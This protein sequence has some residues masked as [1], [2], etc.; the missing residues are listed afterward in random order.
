MTSPLG[1]YARWYFEID[2]SISSNTNIIYH[3]KKILGDKIV[4][5]LFRS[6]FIWE[7]N[8]FTHKIPVDHSN[9]YVAHMDG[10]NLCR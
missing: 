7:K 3:N 2:L 9:H 10:T 6:T 1:K 4:V 8:G 5:P